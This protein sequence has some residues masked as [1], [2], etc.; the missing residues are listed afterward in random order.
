MLKKKSNTLLKITRPDISGMNIY[1]LQT[2]LFVLFKYTFDTFFI[3]IPSLYIC[4]TYLSYCTLFFFVQGERLYL[5]LLAGVRHWAQRCSELLLF[6]QHEINWIQVL[7]WNFIFFIVHLIL[8]ALE[9][10]YWNSSTLMLNSPWRL[11]IELQW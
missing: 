5:G 3:R 9:V 7:E 1:A 4:E 2:Y 11:W 6:W 8:F 10:S